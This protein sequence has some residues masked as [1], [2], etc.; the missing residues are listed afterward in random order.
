MSIQA[1]SYVSENL[2]LEHEL[3]VSAQDSLVNPATGLFIQAGLAQL[4]CWFY[5][6]NAGN[7]I[8]VMSFYLTTSIRIINK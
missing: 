5:Y 6:K 8:Q 4:L 2:K 7:C 1:K 3:Q